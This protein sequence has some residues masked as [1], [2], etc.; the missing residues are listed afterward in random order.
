M[1]AGQIPIVKEQI[2]RLTR[3]DAVI[4]LEEAMRLTTSEEIGR[5]LRATQARLGIAEG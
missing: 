3:G 1:P 5:H 2:R 4:A